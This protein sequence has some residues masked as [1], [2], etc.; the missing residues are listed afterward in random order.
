ML[1]TAKLLFKACGATG[2]FRHYG[3]CIPTAVRMPDKRYE[4][5]DSRYGMMDTGYKIADARPL[6]EMDSKIQILM[7]RNSYSTFNVCAGL[8]LAALI[9][10]QLMVKSVTIKV[11]AVAAT[12]IQYGN[13]IR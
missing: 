7:K 3:G 11:A 2:E 1:A 12:N 5:R 8:T 6:E 4:M 10:C 9:I 13:F